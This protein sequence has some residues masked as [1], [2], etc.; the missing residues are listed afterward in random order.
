MPYPVRTSCTTCSQLTQCGWCAERSACTH[1]TL[2]PCVGAMLNTVSAA[3]A[4]DDDDDVD[5][6]YC[7]RYAFLWYAVCAISLTNHCSTVSSALITP[8]SS[9]HH[10]S[11]HT[12]THTHT[13]IHF[14][15]PH[16]ISPHAVQSAGGSPYRR[17]GGCEGAAQRQLRKCVF[18]IRDA[19][20][21]HS[22]DHCVL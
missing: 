2:M 14:I 15:C 1:A 6:S 20:P 18:V 13:S 16:C 5:V 4:A 9:P 17:R 12:R 21:L 7:V 3:A 19:Y 11:S 10:I 22:V 8:H